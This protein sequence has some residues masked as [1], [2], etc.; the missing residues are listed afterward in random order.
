MAD[1][2]ISELTALAAAPASGDLVEIVD[3]SDTSMAATGTNKKITAA[4][5]L[6]NA[7][8]V[9]GTD[10]AVTDGG[11]GASD[12]ATART[13]LGLAIGTDVQAYDGDLAAIAALT[14][15]AD[16]VPY[17]TGAGT[18]ALADLS[19][20]GRALIDDAT[21]ADQRT[22]LGL[23]IGT[24]VQAYDA[25]LSAI[26]GLTSAADK[27]PYFTGSG[28]A[29]L[30]DFTSAGRALVD[31]ASASAQRT[32]LGLG[33]VATGNHAVQVYVVDGATALTTGDGKAYFMV[34]AALNGL[35]LTAAHAAVVGASTSGTPTVQI[36]NLTDAVDMLSTR[37]TI[38]TSE[39]TSYTAA[40]A[41]VIDGTHDDVATG[42]ILR[43]D[44]DVTGDA[45]GLIVYM[46]FS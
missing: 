35:N 19:S 41:P 40:T 24:N 36:H 23:V 45:T 25:E 9:G 4:N 11:T 29:A 28:S 37:I 10:V 27:V 12:A 1:S 42:D 18:W 15:A 22:T 26:A 13:N 8:Q 30:A 6:A 2:R 34:P 14:S 31:D 46:E 43:I 38:D 20:A 33:S 44:I 7:Y 5:L 16:K 3:V 21:A 39:R 32:T 17:A